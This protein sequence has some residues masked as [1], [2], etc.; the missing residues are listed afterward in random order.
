MKIVN[1]LFIT[2]LGLSPQALAEEVIQRSAGEV[3]VIPDRFPIEDVDYS[4]RDAKLEKRL[5]SY[6]FHLDASTEEATAVALCPK[7]FSTYP[8]VEL[9]ELP[10]GSTKTDYEKKMCNKTV[11]GKN[12]GKKLAKYKNSMSCSKTPSI[13]GYYHVSRALGIDSVPV[14]VLRTMEKSVHQEVADRGRA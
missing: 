7:L 10:V 8:A 3:C 4:K 12:K 11:G 9:I 1:A 6:D 14:S 13:V 2:L 5:C